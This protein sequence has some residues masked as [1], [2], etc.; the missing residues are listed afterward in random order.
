[1]PRS[2]VPTRTRGLAIRAATLLAVSSS[3]GLAQAPRAE[4][5]LDAPTRANLQQ[6][7]D[8]AAAKTG[9]VGAQVSIILGGERADFV[10]GSANVELKLPMTVETVIQIGSTTKV[11]NA[12]MIMTL[13]EQGVLDLDRPVRTWIPNLRLADSMAAASITL[14][15]LLSM[16]SGL[17]NGPYTRHG[18]GDEELGRYVASLGQL[19]QAFRPGQGFGYSNAGTSIAGYAA[20]LATGESWDDLVRKRIFEPAGIRHA[21]TRARD[22]PFQRVSVAHNPA[23][24]SQAPTVR[25]PWYLTQAQGPA[26]STLAMSS[27]DLASFGGL[28]ISDGKAADGSQVLSKASVDAMMTPFV[29]VFSRSYTEQW[30]IGLEREHW[31]GTPVFGHAGGNASGAS[32]LKIFP[33]R[34]GVLALTVNT[35]IAFARFYEMIFDGFGAAVFKTRRAKLVK[36][37]QPV[38]VSDPDR[39][40]G[41]YTM[42]GME[43]EVT[44]AGDQLSLKITVPSPGGGSTNSEYRM[45]PLDRDVFVLESATGSA[46]L[47]DVGFFGD[48][49]KGHAMNLVAPVFAARRVGT[50]N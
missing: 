44:R 35:P 24:G 12:A 10:T 31:S 13:V 6:I 15:Q 14:R 41:R 49:G 9:I 21:V 47:R 17:D 33:E 18:S 32:Y 8:Q 50:G 1:M 43:F 36:P 11:I 28:F 3:T 19:P 4:P 37:A 5:R 38:V 20:E 23:V 45:V 39:Y 22:L 27:H 29:K 34:K 7:V 26:G 16:S 2:D 40:V 25:R 46:P 42:I 30:G 48:D